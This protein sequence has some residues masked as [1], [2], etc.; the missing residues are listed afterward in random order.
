MYFFCFFSKEIHNTVC[1]IL[2]L[3]PNATKAKS[4]LYN[5]LSFI[6]REKISNPKS[7]SFRF[8]TELSFS[9]K[10]CSAYVFLV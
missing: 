4:A 9:K 5:L 8:V 3:I 1:A 10:I 6:C 7:V 2:P